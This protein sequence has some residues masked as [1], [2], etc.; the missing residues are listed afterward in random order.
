MNISN[1]LNIIGLSIDIVGV[2]LIFFYGLPKWVKDDLE[3]DGGTVGI[4]DEAPEHNWRPAL[5]WLGLVA[6]V[7]GFSLQLL[8]NILVK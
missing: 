6:L 3:I 2:L 8:A 5:N 4:D 1:W 7:V